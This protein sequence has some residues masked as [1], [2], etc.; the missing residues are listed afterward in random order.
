MAESISASRLIRFALFYLS[1]CAVKGEKK[2]G[3]GEIATDGLRKT[4]LD[5][6]EITQKGSKT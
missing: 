1:G 3:E 5:W 6:Y 2:P 4:G